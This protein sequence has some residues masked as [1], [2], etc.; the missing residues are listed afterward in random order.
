MEKII[1]HSST[2]LHQPASTM[3]RA[4]GQTS[5]QF[6]NEIGENVEHTNGNSRDHEDLHNEEN[7]EIATDNAEGANYEQST[8][9]LGQTVI[10]ISFL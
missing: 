2:Q 8:D 3:S 7:A 1:T 9:G 5:D 6:A 10:V 4:I